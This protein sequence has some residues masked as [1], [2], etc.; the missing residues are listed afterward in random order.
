M[1]KIVIASAVAMAT[2]VAAGAS[3]AQAT[4]ELKDSASQGGTIGKQSSG[5]TGNGDWVSGNG[6]TAGAPGV[7]NQTT[8]PGS[9]SDIVH[10]SLSAE[11]RG[12]VN[13]NPGNRGSGND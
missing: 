3:H 13:A 12:N 5:A 7:T 9:R 4:L 6:T 8:Y 1:K 10:D 2:V 11:G